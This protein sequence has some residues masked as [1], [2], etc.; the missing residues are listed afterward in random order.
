MA[1]ASQRLALGVQQSQVRKVFT[2]EA[3]VEDEIMPGSPLPLVNIRR[4]WKGFITE[5][6]HRDPVE[7]R[8][9]V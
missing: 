2:K 7:E 1:L 8:I 9:D 4:L 5:I 6:M 3:G